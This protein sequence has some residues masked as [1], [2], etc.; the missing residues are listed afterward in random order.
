MAMSGIF[1]PEEHVELIEGEIVTVM[2]PQLKPHI[3]S[4][5]LIGPALRKAFGDAYSVEAQIPIVLGG[6]SEPE[7]D[8]VVVPGPARRYLERKPTPADIRLLVEVSETSLA[9]DRGRKARLYARHG[10]SDYWIVNLVEG[11]VEV[12]REPDAELGYTAIRIARVGEA[13]APLAI[14]GVQIPVSD[15]LP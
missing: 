6:D 11:C 3:V 15:L 7:P 4:L 12:R 1:G 10:I 8:F 2:P 13:I 9:F 14:P 5:L